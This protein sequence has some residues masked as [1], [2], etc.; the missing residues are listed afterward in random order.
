MCGRGFASLALFPLRSNRAFP[1]DFPRGRGRRGRRSRPK[2]SAA[3]FRL[4]KL[5]EKL[6]RSV[7]RLRRASPPKLGH[8]PCGA[9]RAEPA[10]V[11]LRGAA[12]PRL[13]DPE[14]PRFDFHCCLGPARALAGGFAPLVAD[15][16]AA[17]RASP[18]ATQS[19]RGICCLRQPAFPLAF[20][21]GLGSFRVDSV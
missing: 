3:V 7:F 19:R 15:R 8:C 21:G 9:R 6:P 11:V 4:S 20:R 16:Y 5:A 14:V 12:M 18:I 10:L 1:T 2:P 17:R 13:F